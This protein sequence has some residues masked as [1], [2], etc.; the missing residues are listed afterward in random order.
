MEGSPRA[1]VIED[2]E[3]IIDLVDLTLRLAGFTV[4]IASDEAAA[5]AAAAHDVFDIV[6]ID[7]VR[8]GIDGSEVCRRLRNEASGASDAKIVALTASNRLTTLEWAFAS[9]ADAVLAKPFRPAELVT[10][11]LAEER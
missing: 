9:G 3:T 6:I 11:V 2:D 8:P 4:D 7:L 1:L 10:S 5:I